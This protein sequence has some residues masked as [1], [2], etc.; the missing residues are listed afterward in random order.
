MKII[1]FVDIQFDVAPN[2]TPWIEI[3]R[4]F[5]SKNEVYLVTGY[6]KNKIRIPELK[7]DITFVDGSNIPYI[8]RLVF[9]WKQKKVFIKLLIK[10]KP[11]IVIVNSTNFFLIRL[12][13]SK[14]KKYFF[15]SYLDVRSLSTYEMSLRLLL[16]NF[17]LKKSLKIA[18][19]NFTGITYITEV[20][21][22]YC[23][24]KYKLLPHRAEVWTSGANINLFKPVTISQEDHSFKLIYHGSISIRRQLDCVIKALSLLSDLNIEFNL[25]G[26]GDDIESLRKLSV[27]LN[28]HQNVHFHSMVAYDE[29]PRFINQVD[30]GIL[31]FRDCSVWNTSAPIK[32]FEYLACGK[33]VVVTKIPAHLNVLKGKEFAFWARSSEPIDIAEAI[34]KAYKSKSMFNIMGKRARAFVCNKY[35]WE[36]QAKKLEKFISA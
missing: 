4:Y 26:S 30:V 17:L 25:L 34:R 29:V 14:Q 9:Y 20:I 6:K 21:K 33:P 8:R 32:L 19:K 31:P 15:N 5:Q 2:K 35:S 22:D 10:I 3:I 11:D 12:I 23:K 1:F 28:I 7:K 13:A 27:K 24:E 18:V 36:V 16:E